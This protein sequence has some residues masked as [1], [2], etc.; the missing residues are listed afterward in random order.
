MKIKISALHLDRLAYVYVRQST[1]A[2]VHEHVESKQRQYAL[3]ERAV[4]LG[5]A[6]EAV[7]IVD[8]DQGKSG[9]STEGRDGFARL[10][11]DVAHG[12]VGAIFA[13]EA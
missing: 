6:P 11:H 1:S 5:W 3:A 13:I 4:A 12:K 2:Q 9:A 10:A 7:E 8:E